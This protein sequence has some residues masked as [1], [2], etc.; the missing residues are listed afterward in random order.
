MSGRLV[1]LEGADG[2]GKTTQVERLI[3]HLR[4][5][6]IDAV[7]LREPGGTPLGERIRA[8]LLDL[9]G[10][11]VNDRAELLLFLA[12]RAQL[13]P[14]VTRELAAGRTVVLDRFFLST[15]AYQI[16]GRGLP[17][18]DVRRINAFATLGRVP[19]LTVV[20]A[21]PPEDARARAGEGD[22][23]ERSGIDFYERVAG[24][25][26]MFLTKA[27][28]REHPECGRI[29]GIDARG[30]EDEVADRVWAAVAQVAEV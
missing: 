7:S 28:Q 29:V 9:S 22:R 27:W 10:A 3:A 24:A 18:E 17:E 11:G 20:L 5:R 23:I 8:I 2:V 25:F 13:V 15:Y 1:V 6:G 14:E 19:D 21:L 12:A 30:S 26:G 16:A 4:E